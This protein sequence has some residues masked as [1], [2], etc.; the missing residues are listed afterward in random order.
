[1]ISILIRTHDRQHLLKKCLASLISQSFKG[2]YEIVIIDSASM[3]ETNLVVHEF[4]KIDPNIRYIYEPIAG[5]ARARK[6]GLEVASGDILVWIDDDC[7][8]SDNWLEEITKVFCESEQVDIVGG[9]VI[10]DWEGQRPYWFPDELEGALGRQKL[11]DMVVPVN[12]VNGANIAYKANIAKQVTLDMTALGPVGGSKKRT[13]ED[14]EFCRQAKKLGAKIYYVPDAVV[15][16]HIPKHH[17]TLG[18]LIRRY[19]SFGVSDSVRYQLEYPEDVIDCTKRIGKGMVALMKLLLMFIFKLPFKILD[20][21]K[22]SLINLAYATS[23]VGYLI[24]ETR[25]LIA[26]LKKPTHKGMEMA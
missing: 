19:Y 22:Y 6:R 3:D 15:Y 21:Q 23:L 4:K 24:E 20:L 18:Y 1:M 10:L 5:A 8:A 17:S 13:S 2:Q 16:H 14:V 25:F 9:Q 11:G 26:L 7:I 12:N